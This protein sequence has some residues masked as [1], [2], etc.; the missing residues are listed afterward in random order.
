MPA[1]LILAG[2]R[3][4]SCQDLSSDLKGACVSL[5]ASAS[6]DNRRDVWAVGPT[7]WV[8]PRRGVAKFKFTYRKYNLNRSFLLADGGSMHSIKQS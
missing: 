8:T 7:M 1:Q 5:F 4:Q 3:Y 2:H 6:G